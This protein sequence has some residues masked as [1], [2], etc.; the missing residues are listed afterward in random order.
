VDD[1]DAIAKL[2][3][4]HD[5]VIS[6]VRFSSIDAPKLFAALKKA[7]IKRILVVGG[8]GSLYI[9]P[10]LQ[11]VDTPDFPAAYKSEA[12]GG[13]DFLNALSGQKDL[14]W[15]FLSP[16]AE[17]MP[18]QRTGKFRLGLDQL[19]VGS[20][21]KSWISREDYSVALLDEVETPKHVQ[22]RFTVGY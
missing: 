14:S 3:T 6:S 21:G 8:A 15:T 7:G 17:I 9:K 5:A 10:D 22:K 2:L 18:G 13:R 12:L 1:S 11:V 19:L 4:G 16:S 20:D